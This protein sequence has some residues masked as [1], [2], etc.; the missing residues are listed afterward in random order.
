MLVS[1]APGS[2]LALD[3]DQLSHSSSMWVLL[4]LG[5]RFALDLDQLSRS[6]SMWVSLALGSRLALRFG[7]AQPFRFNEGF[8]RHWFTFS[9]ILSI[10]GLRS[11]PWPE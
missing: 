10:S 6:V 7:S 9:P 5:S 8:A 2:C 1:F 4:A 3:L 11:T